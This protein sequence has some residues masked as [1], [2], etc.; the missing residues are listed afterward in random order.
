MW[1]NY[2]HIHNWVEGP[3]LVDSSGSQD[4]EFESYNGCQKN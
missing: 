3:M 1:D 4:F 2:R